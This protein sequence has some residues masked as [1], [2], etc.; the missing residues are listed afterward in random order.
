L[1]RSESALGLSN[2]LNSGGILQIIAHNI[3][4]GLKFLADQLACDFEGCT[5]LM[6]KNLSAS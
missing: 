1:S 6:G 2:R 4:L 5:R 3:C